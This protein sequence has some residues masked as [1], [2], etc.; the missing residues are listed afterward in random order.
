[1]GAP[2]KESP[3]IWGIISWEKDANKEGRKE[4]KNLEKRAVK[5]SG[6]K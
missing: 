4:P 5:R 3:E 2:R 6:E 1:M